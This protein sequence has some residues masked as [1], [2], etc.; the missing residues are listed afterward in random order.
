MTKKQNFC[1]NFGTS[2]GANRGMENII[3]ECLEMPIK[4]ITV[5]RVL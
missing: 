5:E 4:I 2:A 1:N 3:I